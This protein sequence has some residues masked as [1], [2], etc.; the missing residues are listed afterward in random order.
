MRGQRESVDGRNLFLPL[1][2]PFGTPRA[3]FPTRFVQTSALYPRK[4][5]IAPRRRRERACKRTD[6]A[7][8]TFCGKEERRNARA[9]MGTSLRTICSPRRRGGVPYED[10][11]DFHRV[12]RKKLV[13][14]RRR[15]ER[16]RKRTDAASGTFCGCKQVPLPLGGEGCK[17]LCKFFSQ[18]KGLN[19][20]H[21]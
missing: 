3:A 12:P 10:C 2:L 21:L 4:K 15:R 7:S 1:W 5:L 13:A 6:A 20:E 9:M 18:G 8:G 19:Q 14:L 16:A 17:C 11:T